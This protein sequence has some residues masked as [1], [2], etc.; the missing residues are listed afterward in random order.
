MTIRD[1]PRVNVVGELSLV[2]AAVAV[3]VALV[4]HSLKEKAMLAERVKGPYGAGELFD[5][6]GVRG[7]SERA[8][9]YIVMRSNCVFCSASLP[10]YRTAIDQARA[11]QLRTV[12][13]MLE[14]KTTGE[15]YLIGNHIG[16]DKVVTTREKV[17]RVTA[18]PTTILVDRHGMVIRSWTGQ[19]PVSSEKEVIEAIGSLK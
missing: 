7:G 9:L 3:C 8:T 4:V 10:F 5:L 16:F 17:K 11:Q 15:Q 2:I 12:A 18:I 1:V 14:D 13:V 19:L 6:E